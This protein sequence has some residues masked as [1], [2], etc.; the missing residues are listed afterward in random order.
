MERVIYKSVIAIRHDIAETQ[1][2]R[3]RAV[4][5]AAFQNRAGCVKN[6][7]EAPYQLVFAGGEGE[8]GCLEVG[9]LN[10][11]RESDFFPFLSAWQWIDEDPDECCDLLK[12]LQK[13]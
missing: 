13:L 5:E 8:Y 4:A 9:M 2:Q 10:L 7:S 12:L 11:K 6:I 3:V 1:L